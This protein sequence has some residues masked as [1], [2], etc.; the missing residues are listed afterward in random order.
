MQDDK[1]RADTKE[2]SEDLSRIRTGAERLLAERSGRAECGFCSPEA[3]LTSE[4]C[5]SSL[6]ALGSNVGCEA[7][8]FDIR[9]LSVGSG[10]LRIRR[11]QSGLARYYF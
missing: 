10:G 5:R 4:N 6:K 7:T 3:A 2:D 8:S 9:S 1:K 11:A